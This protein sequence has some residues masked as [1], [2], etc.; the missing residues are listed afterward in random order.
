MTPLRARRLGSRF[1][2]NV[3]LWAG[4]ILVALPALWAVVGSFK[5]QG[6][7]FSH[8]AAIWRGQWILGNYHTLFGQ[9]PFGTWYLNSAIV[10]VSVTVVSLLASA[11]AG[12]AF[13]KYE[14]GG[15]RP[16]FAVVIASLAIP[17]I[18][19]VIPLYGEIAKLHLV[20]NLVAVILPFLAPGFGI[21]LMRQYITTIPTSL[22]EAARIDGGS[23][24]YVFFRVILPLA[25]P[26]LGAL[27]V[28]T[29]VT[30]WGTFL[31]PLMV[32]NSTGRFTLPLG[33]Y[34]VFGAGGNGSRAYYGVMLAGSALIS[35][36]PL[37]VFFRMQRAFVSGLTL[38]GVEE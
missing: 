25:R 34:A 29:F 27:A 10:S 32:L 17:L 31:W 1:L 9:W 2:L 18:G 12:F 22:V 16:L 24:L 4:G 15:K 35:I 7:I 13:A 20:N 30:Q 23:D 33:L 19:I 5:T 8:P 26:A 21:F 37:L 3:A 38:G 14:F 28:V 11:A 6:A 36:P